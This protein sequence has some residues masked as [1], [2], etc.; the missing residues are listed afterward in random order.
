MG[1]PLPGDN[2]QG[3]LD[4]SLYRRAKHIKVRQIKNSYELLL[5]KSD[6]FC[7]GQE[8]IFGPWDGRRQRP[9]A[10][11]DGVCQ[12][13]GRLQ[14]AISAT[15]QF[16]FSGSGHKLNYVRLVFFAIKDHCKHSI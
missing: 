8:L 6:D 10:K 11:L 15:G 3:Y 13:S 5:N 16:N 9:P 4:G 12:P 7:T 14:C 1:L 2:F